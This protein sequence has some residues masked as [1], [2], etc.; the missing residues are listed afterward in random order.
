[1]FSLVCIGL[2]AFSFPM[3]IVASTITRSARFFLV[4]WVVKKFGPAMMRTDASVWAL[5]VA[6]WG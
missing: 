1:M 3:F 6:N 2:A 4:A 5:W